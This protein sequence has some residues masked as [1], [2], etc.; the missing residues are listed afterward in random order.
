MRR[1]RTS[2]PGPYMYGACG[3]IQCPT[4][5]RGCPQAKASRREIGMAFT[6]ACCDQGRRPDIH[7]LLQTF[8]ATWIDSGLALC[9]W[10]IA[11]QYFRRSVPQTHRGT[12]CL[13]QR[14]GICELHVN[15]EVREQKRV[16]REHRRNHR[17]SIRAPP[18]CCAAKELLMGAANGGELATR[19]VTR[20]VTLSCDR[21]PA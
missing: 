4:P 11:C 18:T 7:S 16:Q 6:R 21:D 17:S 8:R 3:L 20:C 19:A 15:A 1:G 10:R 12:A 13:Y 5:G 9:L 2:G 14:V